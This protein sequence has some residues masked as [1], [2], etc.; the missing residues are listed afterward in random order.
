MGLAGLCLISWM[1]TLHFR[2]NRFNS[3]SNESFMLWMRMSNEIPNDRPLVGISVKENVEFWTAEKHFNFYYNRALYVVLVAS[4]VTINIQIFLVSYNV[5]TCNYLIVQ[6][7]HSI[8][9]YFFIRAYFQL[10]YTPNVFHQKVRLHQTT[11]DR[12]TG[13]RV[14]PKTRRTSPRF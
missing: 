1:T 7:V 9:H 4:Y 2:L 14:R 8:H 13:V 6:C 10:L 5:D 12:L 11:S 3:A